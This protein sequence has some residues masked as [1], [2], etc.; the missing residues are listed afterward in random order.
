MVSF[1]RLKY[2]YNIDGPMNLTGV[3]NARGTRYTH[4]LFVI[5]PAV[6]IIILFRINRR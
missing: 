5:F 1:H 3:K 4:L 2:C 6:N